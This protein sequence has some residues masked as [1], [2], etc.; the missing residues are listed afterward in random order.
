MET[1]YFSIKINEPQIQIAFTKRFSFLFYIYHGDALWDARRSIIPCHVFH[2]LVNGCPCTE[3]RIRLIEPDVSF[4]GPEWDMQVGWYNVIQ[5]SV[6]NFGDGIWLK[7]KGT[8]ILFQ[9]WARK[10]SNNVQT[11]CANSAIHW[12]LTSLHVDDIS[13]TLCRLL[14]IFW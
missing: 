9:Q 3:F 2:C 5:A 6:S 7:A 13:S 8:L 14:N 1:I 4:G 11:N 12:Q 10:S